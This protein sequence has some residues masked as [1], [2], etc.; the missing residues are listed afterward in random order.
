MDRC[1]EEHRVCNVFGSQCLK[2]GPNEKKCTRER[3]HDGPHIACGVGKHN[4]EIWRDNHIASSSV[5]VPDAFLHFSPLDTIMRGFYGELR[6]MPQFEVSEPEEPELEE[7]KDPVVLWDDIIGLEDAKEQLQQAIEAPFLHKEVYRAFGMTPPKGVLLYGPHGCGKTML[8]K[9][10]AAA[11]AKVHG[12]STSEGF[13][14]YNGAE[15]FGPHVG[16][17]ERWLRDA[18]E[19]AETFHKRNGYPAILFFDEA[20]SMLPHREISPPWTRN[21]VNQF[22]SLT[23][24]LK[25]SN[26]FVILATNNHEMLDQAAIR[27]GRIDRKIYISPP[28]KKAIRAIVETAF[29]KKPHHNGCIDLVMSELYNERRYIGEKQFCDFINGANAANIADVAAS[30]AFS[31]VLKEK[32]G[33]QVLEITA[34]DTKKAIDILFDEIVEFSKGIESIRNRKVEFNINHNINDGKGKDP[35]DLF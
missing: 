15:M 16:H 22:L 17:E 27:T 31:R 1:T 9:A 32:E 33:F 26:V 5:H 10:A 19:M 30:V 18:F 24:G 2:W 28:S 21:A 20:D 35:E 25:A 7:K 14:Y 8:G 11:M 34:D 13:F 23:D 29:N 6:G 3:G 12:K 4:L